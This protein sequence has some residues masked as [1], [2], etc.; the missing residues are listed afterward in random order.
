MNL[1]Q[2]I[3][4]EEI[5]KAGKTIPEFRPGDTLILCSRGL[6]MVEDGPLLAFV[7]SRPHPAEAC[8]AILDAGLPARGEH[9]LTA[10]VVRAIDT[11]SEAVAPGD[12]AFTTCSAASRRGDAAPRWSRRRA[13]R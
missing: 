10:I 1:I 9:N 8:K 2:T 6:A 5:A 11:A 13:R 3:E 12:G 7:N 4:A